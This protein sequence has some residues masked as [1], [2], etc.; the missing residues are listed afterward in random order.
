VQELL[1][2]RA[3]QY[4]WLLTRAVAN[5]NP[6]AGVLC[7]LVSGAHML[8]DAIRSSSRRAFQIL[9]DVH[10]SLAFAQQGRNFPWSGTLLFG[11][12]GRNK[13][14]KAGDDAARNIRWIEEFAPHT[15]K[16]Q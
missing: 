9:S 2:D 1:L 13:D 12:L 11:R 7:E 14:T 15:A 10:R 5:T 8:I 6:G 16:T 4:L 3:R